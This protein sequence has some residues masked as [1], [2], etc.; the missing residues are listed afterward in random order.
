MDRIRRTAH[1]VSVFFSGVV[2]IGA[3]LALAFLGVIGTILTA[4]DLLNLNVDPGVL[5]FPAAMIVAGN[6][7]YRERQ[8]RQR[9]EVERDAAK[10]ALEAKPDEA[11]VLRLFLRLH[12]FGPTVSKPFHTT[13]EELP[14]T[15]PQGEK[16]YAEWIALCTEAITAH[17]PAFA[18]AFREAQ[19][20]N[21]AAYRGM[22]VIVKDDEDR[23]VYV[24]VDRSRRY[25]DLIAQ[26]MKVLADII[27]AG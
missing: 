3:F 2:G 27:R 18:L 7:I 21:L 11:A 20:V 10:A 19:A 25:D 8:T 6:L 15:M 22:Y 13:L 23:D 12:D 26:A 24:D 9:A 16:M 4:T 1:R 17:R 5:F 14:K